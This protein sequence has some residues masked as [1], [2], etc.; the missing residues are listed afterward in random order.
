MEYLEKYAIFFTVQ[1]LVDLDLLSSPRW[2]LSHVAASIVAASRFQ[3]H[4]FPV[5]PQE[6]E[7]LTTYSVHELWGCIRQ[8]M[9]KFEANHERLVRAFFPEVPPAA[10]DKMMCS[11]ADQVSPKGPLDRMDDLYEGISPSGSPVARVRKQGGLE[12]GERVASRQPLVQLD[13]NAVGQEG[14]SSRLFD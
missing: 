13:G 14:R 4:I 6:L 1:C 10:H 9:R 12:E 5:W 11:T 2:R 7:A 8:I 3:L